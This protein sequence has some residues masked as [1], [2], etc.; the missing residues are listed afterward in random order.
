MN[1]CSLIYYA[2]LSRSIMQL[3][4]DGNFMWNGNEWL[5]V[6]SAPVTEVAAP[7]E[8]QET[9]QVTD[10][11]GMPQMVAPVVVVTSTPG[12]KPAI[13]MA[14]ALSVFKYGIIA[15]AGWIVSMLSIIHI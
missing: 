11:V 15:L 3:S 4:D 6:E 14:A 5:P 8:V 1:I 12:G 9:P 7:V 2:G 13:N 10:V